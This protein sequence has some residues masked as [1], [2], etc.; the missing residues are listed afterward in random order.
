MTGIVILVCGE[1]QA[2]HS[3]TEP[4]ALRTGPLDCSRVLNPRKGM[5]DKQD[6]RDGWHRLDHRINVYLPALDHNWSVC[7]IRA[8]AQPSYKIITHLRMFGRPTCI[9]SSGFR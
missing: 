9:R 5:T 2:A 3:L 7:S 8:Q 4:R 6:D 1:G